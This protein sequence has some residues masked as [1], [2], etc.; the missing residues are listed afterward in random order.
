MHNLTGFPTNLKE[1]KYYISVLRYVSSNHVVHFSLHA[2]FSQAQSHISRSKIRIRFIAKS[3]SYLQLS[4]FHQQHIEQLHTAYQSY[5]HHQIGSKEKQTPC[6][7]QGP[8][9]KMS[10]LSRSRLTMEITLVSSERS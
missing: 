10:V 8:F 1:P 9:L 5:V 7:T 4:V 2:L 3:S 6:C